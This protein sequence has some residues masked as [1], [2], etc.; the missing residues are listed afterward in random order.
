MSVFATEGTFE[1]IMEMCLTIQSFTLKEN[2]NQN[3][4]IGKEIQ[5][6]EFQVKSQS[7][8]LMHG[9]AIVDTTCKFHVG[10]THIKYRKIN[11]IVAD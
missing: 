4:T 3:K 9:I 7:C 1:T 10:S 8:I 2:R 6:D 5:Y 11:L